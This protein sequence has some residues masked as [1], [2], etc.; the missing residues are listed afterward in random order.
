MV[1][2]RIAIIRTGYPQLSL[3]SY[4]VQEIGF[5]KALCELG[6]DVDLYSL[7]IEEDR[8]RTVYESNG[9]QVRIVPLQKKWGLCA[10]FAYYPGLTSKLQKGDYRILHVIG[11]SELMSALILRKFGKSNHIC[12]FLEGM[13][14]DYRGWK[15]I[16]Q[17][18]FDFIFKSCITQGANLHFAKTS[19]C[20]QYLLQKGYP[21]VELLPIGLDVQPLASTEQEDG[22]FLQPSPP[23]LLYIGRLEPRRN[24]LFL[25]H[26]LAEVR[27]TQPD[28]KL[29]V[30]GDGPL[31]Q[32]FDQEVVHLGLQ[33]FV[34][35]IPQIDN[36]EIGSK[37]K[38]SS[39]LLLPTHYEIYGMVVMEALFFGLP[40]VAS[41][42]AGPESIL[43]EETLGTCLHGWNAEQWAACALKYMLEPDPALAVRRKQ[44]ALQNFRWQTIARNYLEFIN[45]LTDSSPHRR[46]PLST[47]SSKN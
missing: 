17:A 6:H 36:K 26:V 5:A 20:R 9:R 39:V 21:R 29:L 42:E 40:V 23:R 25:L 38:Q 10:G 34:E 18:G 22:P 30:V 32:Q 15:R 2:L 43:V 45:Q 44:Y 1:S 27:R 33:A 7:F 12:T 14:S 35:R 16:L 11:Q 13:Y 31:A 24:P 46:S 4:N 47:Q 3:R 37:C 41:A 19:R 28:A 8:E